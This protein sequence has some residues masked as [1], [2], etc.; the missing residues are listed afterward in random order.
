MLSCVV[1]TRTWA[2]CDG[3]FSLVLLGSFSGVFESASWVGGA[4]VSGAAV[5]LV[6]GGVIDVGVVGTE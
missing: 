3:R 6:V 4:K 5:V 2:V 1:V